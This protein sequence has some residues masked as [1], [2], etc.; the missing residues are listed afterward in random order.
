MT[1]TE[2]KI[3]I[4]FSTPF[5][6]ARVK[7]F[8][9][10][11]QQVRQNLTRFCQACARAYQDPEARP[12]MEEM[13]PRLL[14]QLPEAAINVQARLGKMMRGE[15][16]PSPYLQ[17]IVADDTDVKH[18]KIPEEKFL[19]VLH[20]CLTEQDARILN[21]YGVEIIAPI[22]DTLDRS[23]HFDP[24]DLPESIRDVP[25]DPSNSNHQQLVFESAAFDAWVKASAG[26]IGTDTYDYITG[27]L[28]NRDR[29]SLH[30]EFGDKRSHRCGVNQYGHRFWL[31]NI[32]N[33]FAKA[34]G[35]EKGDDLPR[36]KQRCFVAF[37]QASGL[38][39][40]M[41][42]ENSDQPGPQLTPAV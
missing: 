17:G 10:S 22:P 21:K 18:R 28:C 1:K 4:D 34:I 26:Y 6:P 33:T 11:I 38:A 14:N 40:V 7:K 3:T 19:Y 8:V 36:F 35:C 16:D 25:L 39:L 27:T 37:A 20:R 32:S 13:I 5:K 41:G 29:I 31:S 24:K 42:K 12:Y 30:K 9:H 2:S 15:A 23:Y